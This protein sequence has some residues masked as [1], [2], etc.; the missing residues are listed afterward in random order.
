[1]FLIFSS[2]FNTEPLYIEYGDIYFGGLPKGFKTPRNVLATTAYFIGCISDVTIGGQIVNFANSTDRKSAQLDNCS[3]D[4]LGN[5]KCD[6]LKV[7][8]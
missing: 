3:R 8:N 4:I 5:L 6:F 7:I 2:D 1:M